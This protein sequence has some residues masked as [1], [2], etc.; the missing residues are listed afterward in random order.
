MGGCSNNLISCQRVNSDDV[1]APYEIPT[2]WVQVD[3]ETARLLEDICC[4]G[5]CTHCQFGWMDDCF[6]S[7]GDRG[8]DPKSEWWNTK[9]SSYV[10]LDYYKFLLNFVV[11]CEQ[12]N[13]DLKQMWRTQREWEYVQDQFFKKYRV[14]LA[15]QRLF[16]VLQT[17]MFRQSFNPISVQGNFL[18]LPPNVTMPPPLFN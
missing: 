8:L 2:E 7:G 15:R 13:I 9:E 14:F 6:Y 16:I 4:V 17:R 18:P 3:I 11:W 12:N 10:G 5:G 1:K